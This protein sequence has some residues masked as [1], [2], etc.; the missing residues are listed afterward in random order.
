MNT[1][2]NY[3]SNY[4]SYDKRVPRYILDEWDYITSRINKYIVTNN[5]RI[6][7]GNKNEKCQLGKKTYK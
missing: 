1:E 5:G 6:K 2:N 7:G 4:M 3:M